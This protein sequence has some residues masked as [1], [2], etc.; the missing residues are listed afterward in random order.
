M[1]APL[2]YD[3]IE[4]AAN[5]RRN[6]YNWPVI[7]A[8]VARFPL[9]C[10]ANIIHIY[11]KIA[12]PFV[13]LHIGCFAA[14]RTSANKKDIRACNGV[15]LFI[16][17]NPVQPRRR[18]LKRLLVFGVFLCVALLA[19]RFEVV[20]IQGYFRVIHIR[21]CNVFNMVDNARGPAAIL[22]YV[23]DAA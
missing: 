16:K 21:R 19:Y 13:F 10:S 22:A 2:L 14:P 20:P 15:T 1:P 17:G 3:L 11:D 8:N 12:R 4:K 9:Q 18:S 6:R 7:R 23:I 5:L